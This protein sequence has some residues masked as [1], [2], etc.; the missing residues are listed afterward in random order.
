M[1]GIMMIFVM[2]IILFIHIIVAYLFSK[3]GKDSSIK[4]FMFGSLGFLLVFS[5]FFGDHVVKYLYI[6]GSCVVLN[7]EVTY[8]KKLYDEYTTHV[9]EINYNSY[10]PENEEKHKIRNIIYTFDID[11]E[12]ITSLRVDSK[13]KKWI[14]YFIDETEGGVLVKKYKLANLDFKKVFYEDV[15]A[16]GGQGG[17]F[18]KTINSIV[19]GYSC[20]INCK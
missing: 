2:G 16:W 14:S 15:S 18:C 11:A 8:D 4:R 10:K 13:T 5:L 12:N 20:P 6:K 17:W 9:K 3:F 19:V 1:L 7:K